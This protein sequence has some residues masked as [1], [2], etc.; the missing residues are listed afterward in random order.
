MTGNRALIL[1]DVQQEYFNGPLEVRYPPVA[2][3]LTKITQVIDAAASAGLPIAVIQ[4]DAGSESPVFNP[5]SSSFDLHPEIEERRI[6]D[7]KHIVKQ[8]SSIFAQ[9]E[10]LDW[11]RENAVDT[12]T[13][14]GFMT[15]NC[16]LASSVEAEALGI[17]VEVLNDAT[18]AI[19]IAN[20]AGTVD[21]KTVHTTLMA[22]LNSNW[23]AV[24]DSAT[25]MTAT[26]S[27]DLL[28]KSNLVVSAIDGAEK[29]NQ[30]A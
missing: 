8:Y 15:N 27:G 6:G 25:W 19:N 5:T 4:H 29:A 22:L 17:A 26:A 1:I 10:L 2:D 11:L 28:E 30:P 12:V 13:L 18:G 23:A 3:A 21:A 24:T 9:T 7:W 20:Q 16:V 14:V